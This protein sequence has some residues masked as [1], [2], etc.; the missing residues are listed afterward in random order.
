MIY[1]NS[2]YLLMMKNKLITNIY[3]IKNGRK[4]FAIPDL[5]SWIEDNICS[6]F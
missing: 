1:T 6:V 4:I 2:W 3:V 5:Q